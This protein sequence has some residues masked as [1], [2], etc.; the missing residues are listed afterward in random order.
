MH[1]SLS[2]AQP[3]GVFRFSRLHRHTC[4]RYLAKITVHPEP[5]TII[6]SWDEDEGDA[7]DITIS[8]WVHDGTALSFLYFENGIVSQAILELAMGFCFCS[9]CMCILRP[10]TSITAHQQH[11]FTGAVPVLPAGFIPQYR[12]P[13]CVRL[14]RVRVE[15]DYIMLILVSIEHPITAFRL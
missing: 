12:Q 5:T 13:L 1:P 4:I 14:C 15:D 11:L 2:V 8:V 9:V 10:Y 3:H 6:L 7:R